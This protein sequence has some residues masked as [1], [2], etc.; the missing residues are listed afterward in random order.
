MKAA[1]KV[2]P[3]WKQRQFKAKSR[4]CFIL[5]PFRE[6]WSER[7][8]IIIRDI[9]K[10]YGLEG[11]RADNMYGQDV[12][13]D[14]WTG[15]NSS[16]VVIADLSKRNPNV[17]YELGIVHTIGKKVISLAQSSKDI[18]FDLK[19]L[20]HILY[21]DNADGYKILRKEIP[22]A[23]SALRINPVTVPLP[24]D[25]SIAIPQKRVPRRITKLLGKWEGNWDGK[26]SHILVVEEIKPPT[27]TVV[28]AW[29][30]S[31]EWN[32]QRNWRRVKGKVLEDG[33]FL[34]LP[35]GAKVKYSMVNDATLLDATY[36]RGGGIAKAKMRKLRE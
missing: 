7:I 14:I 1:I 13:E 24:D 19:R 23:L 9:L 21:K 36:E 27:A 25:L 34:N 33:L 10:D 18:P 17:F 3:I 30:D 26:L 31:V 35:N 8:W 28:Y 29:G 16:A 20:R 6:E 12:M 2:A 4:Q 11:I 15:I 5:M 22:A 32:I